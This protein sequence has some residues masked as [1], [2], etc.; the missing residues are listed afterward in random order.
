MNSK[1]KNLSKIELF[2]LFLIVCVSA[3]LALP[4]VNS[5]FFYQKINEAPSTNSQLKE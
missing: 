5:Y 3:F 1:N 4:I 2:I